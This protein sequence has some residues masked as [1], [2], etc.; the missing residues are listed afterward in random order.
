MKRILSIIMAIAIPVIMSAQAQITTK[1]FRLQDF[2]T[3]TTKVVIPAD[4][5]YGT[6]LKEAVSSTW[7]VSPFEFCTPEEFEK[8]KNSEDFYFLITVSGQFKK[9]SAPGINL[10]TLCKGGTKSGS[11]DDMLEVATIPVSAINSPSGREVVFLPALLDIVQNHA[12]ASTEREFDAYTGLQYYSGNLSKSKDMTILFA[13]EDLNDEAKT[14][15]AE[16]YYDVDTQIVDADETDEAM[17]KKTP[18]TVA[19]FTV[20]PAD[21][22]VGSF[23]YKMLIDCESHQLYYFRK[24]KITKKAGAGFLIEDIKRIASARK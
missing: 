11:I 18:D 6:C 2:T 10:L 8:I 5:F 1:K 17:E 20:V 9:E 12:I 23:C 19:S 16:D 14:D 4:D 3:K 21:A 22:Q 7:R 15:E 13:A 24:H